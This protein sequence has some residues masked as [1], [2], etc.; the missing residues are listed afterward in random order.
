MASTVRKRPAWRAPIAA[1]AAD[2]HRPERVS[3]MDN[4]RPADT[5]AGRMQ[6]KEQPPAAEPAIMPTDQQGGGDACDQWRTD[7][8]L[9]FAVVALAFGFVMKLV[10]QARETNATSLAI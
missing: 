7:L 10:R 2:C 9:S 8:V 3:E 5:R 1:H 6:Y 4:D